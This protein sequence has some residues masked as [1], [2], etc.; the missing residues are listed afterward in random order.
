MSASIQIHNSIMLWAHSKDT[1]WYIGRK[2]KLQTQFG[3]LILM[4]L[5]FVD[6]LKVLSRVSLE[7]KK[8]KKCNCWTRICGEARDQKSKYVSSG[9]PLAR[10][11]FYKW[12]ALLIVFSEF[13]PIFCM[14][15]GFFLEF[16]TFIDLFTLFGS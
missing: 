12:P 5:Q 4:L 1:V 16:F 14:K 13:T 8:N 6:F 11:L 2:Y 9:F 15:N 10:Q 7:D 3:S